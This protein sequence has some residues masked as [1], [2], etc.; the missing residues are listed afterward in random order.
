VSITPLLG[1]LGV[2]GLAVALALQ[3]TL[4]NL[5]AGVHILASKKV[6][7]GDYVALDGGQEGYIVDINWRNTTIR[8]I[9]GNLVV[10]PNSRF[11][12]AI[13]TNFHQ[14]A[15]DMS[16]LVPVG[17]SYD[18][19]LDEVERVT[20]EVAR[21]VLKEVEGG[22]PDHEPLVRFNGFGESS[23]DFSVILRSREFGD[24][25]RLVHEFIK[26]LHR[27]YGA[28]GIEIPYPIRTLLMNKPTGNGH[29]EAGRGTQ[30]SP[31]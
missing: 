4:A 2:G 5:F 6:Q 31:T 15:Q 29:L 3:D 18:S 27:R 16:V 8:Q 24:Q 25:Y 17:V 14:P 21:E 11:A 30:T 10:V 13:M 26:R 23:I 28:E 22:V 19:D 1:A 9:Q 20:L 7:Q 12:D